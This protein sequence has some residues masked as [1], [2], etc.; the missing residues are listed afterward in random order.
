M[1]NLEVFGILPIVS[2]SKELNGEDKSG[3]GDIW[4]GAKYAVM[5][6]GALTI[7]GALDLPTGSDKDG[8]GNEG[9]FGIDVAALTAK[10]MDK[11]GIDGQVGVR[12]NAEGPKDAGKITPGI[13]VYVNVE[14]SYAIMDKLDGFL[15]IEY[16]MAG[17]QKADGT[18]VDKSSMAVCNLNVGAK[19]MCMEKCGLRGD[20]FFPVTAKNTWTGDA[21][22]II[23]LV[24]GVK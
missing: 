20:V 3:I 12:W 24:I 16:A 19:Y 5:P 14:G 2:I 4:L 7:R 6:E 15:G 10:K 18:K 22:I 11:F 21:G 17:D 1:E 8:L 9:G 13:G 23:S